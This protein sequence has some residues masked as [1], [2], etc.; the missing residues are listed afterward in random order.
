MNSQIS[1]TS[2]RPCCQ[3]L[4]Q[5][6]RV[7]TPALRRH[8]LLNKKFGNK[9]GLSLRQAEYVCE[10]GDVSDAESPA[11]PPV[12]SESQVDKLEHFVRSSQ[13]NRFIIYLELATMQFSHWNFCEKA[14]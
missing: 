6:Q 8:R 12:L 7:T 5:D 2:K 13:V 14:L 4:N 9:L 1:R 3:N 10:I 11:R